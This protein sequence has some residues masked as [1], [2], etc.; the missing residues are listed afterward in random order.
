MIRATVS[1]VIALAVAGGAVTV[2][3][4]G[5]KDATHRSTSCV[6][7][8][9]RAV[10]VLADHHHLATT[11]S[12]HVA[13]TTRPATS[14]PHTAFVVE[15]GVYRAAIPDE[16]AVHDLEHG[17]VVI[18]YA[19]TLAKGDLATLL[20]VARSFPRDVLLAPYP[21]LAQPIAL[22]A[23]G[24]IETLQH[25]DAARIEAFVQALRGRYDHGWQAGARDCG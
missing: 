22:T 25:A 4:G 19:P 1:V 23:W 6:A 16:L 3:L 21:G 18:R 11:H 10:P 8:P 5:T 24:R 20:D 15:P 2:V 12:P 13:Y 7:L 14:G 9:G 17:H